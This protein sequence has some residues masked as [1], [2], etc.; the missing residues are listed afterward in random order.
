MC[1]HIYVKEELSVLIERALS[2]QSSIF[3]QATAMRHLCV[4][5]NMT[6]SALA[7]RLG[8]S[9]STVGNKIRL[10]QYSLGERE[11]VLKHGLSERH[12]RA[13]LRIC[14]PKREK[15]IETV[16][17]M[18]LT[19]QQTEELVEKYHRETHHPASGERITR[20][21][22]SADS[23]ITSTQS[24]ADQ[25]RRIGYKVTCLTE[26]GDHWRKIS[27]TVCE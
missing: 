8:V 14:S 23:F 20:D 24:G 16:G 1:D 13:L 27:I 17:N 12:A 2:D 5:L 4:R 15:M 21:P 11:L 10:L 3:E 26:T 19:V 22:L 9:Q 7:K 18:H 6:Q 25:L